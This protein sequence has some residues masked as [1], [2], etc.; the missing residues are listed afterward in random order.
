MY[1]TRTFLLEVQF[2]GAFTA[3]TLLTLPFIIG[4]VVC[5]QLTESATSVLHIIF[6]LVCVCE[7]KDVRAV[8]SILRFGVFMWFYID[9][10]GGNPQ[11]IVY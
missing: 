7:K 9:C 8:Y 11:V 3:N 4:P 1:R 6:I 10:V 2:M 5:H